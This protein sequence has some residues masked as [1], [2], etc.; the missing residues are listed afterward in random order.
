MREKMTQQCI[1]D[2]ETALLEYVEKYGPTEQAKRVISRLTIARVAF[3]NNLD[4]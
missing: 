2:L 4:Q 1:I 3:G